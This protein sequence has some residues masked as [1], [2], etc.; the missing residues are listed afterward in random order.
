VS[1]QAFAKQLRP[2]HID[3]E[4]EQPDGA[5]PMTYKPHAV[6]EWLHTNEAEDVAAS[7]RH[8]LRC[9]AMI[10]EDP[11]A[12][13]WLA[14]ALHASLQGALGVRSHGLMV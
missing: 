9:R 1:Q 7:V 12:W 3:M 8:A 13:K 5:G 10:Q 11:H 6:G 14:L 4:L 2:R